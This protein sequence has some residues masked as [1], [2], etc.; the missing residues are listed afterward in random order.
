MRYKIYLISK[1]PVRL[2]PYQ[3]S[4]PRLK[5]RRQKIDQILQE[6]T[7]RSSTSAYSSPMFL[8][9]IGDDFR[10]VVDYSTLIKGSVWSLC[11]YPMFKSQRIGSQTLRYIQYWTLI[12]PTSKFHFR[13]NHTALATP[14]NLFQFTRL[15]FGLCSGSGVVTRLLDKVF[16]DIK[17]QYVLKYLDYLVVYFSDLPTHM[18]I[19]NKYL[20]ALQLPVSRL[21]CQSSLSQPPNCI[22]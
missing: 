16:G 10:P 15:A 11:H 19:F 7:I 3:L 6:W 18:A 4:P 1:D 20:H 21:S 14:W 5:I 12:R 17:F 9:P 22:F 2:P 8:V 13:K